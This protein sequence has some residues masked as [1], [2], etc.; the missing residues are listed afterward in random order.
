MLIIISGYVFIIFLIAF[1]KVIE[2]FSGN[3]KD[4]VMG[5]LLVYMPVLLLSLSVF[6]EKVTLWLI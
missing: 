2:A 6:I 3:K 5:V 1:P 4:M